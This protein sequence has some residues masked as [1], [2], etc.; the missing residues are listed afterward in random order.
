[1]SPPWQIPWP[2]TMSERMRIVTLALPGPQASIDIP[3]WR[4]AESPRHRASTARSAR[5]CRA[6]ESRPGRD[7][8]IASLTSREARRALPGERGNAFRVVVR[9]PE[10]ALE[11]ALEVELPGQCRRRGRVHRLARAHEAA[12]RR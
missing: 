2:L 11:V 6:S 3:S 5:R 7:S 12:R 9:I 1:M 4:E 8:L 10:L